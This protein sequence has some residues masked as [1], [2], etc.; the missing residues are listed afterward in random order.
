VL[1]TNGSGYWT[2]RQTVTATADYRFRWQPE[3]PYGAPTGPVRT[4]DVLRVRLER[5]R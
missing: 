3:D 1:S 2:L 4:S 5:M